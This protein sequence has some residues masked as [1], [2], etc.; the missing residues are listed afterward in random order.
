VRVR[1]VEV[2]VSEGKCGV[3]GLGF[4]PCMVLLAQAAP[5]VG[6]K[7][8]PATFEV[9]SRGLPS[10][11]PLSEAVDPVKDTVIGSL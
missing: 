4:S 5:M 7:E 3:A 6:V 10:S 1:A 11:V 2:A 9:E 8:E